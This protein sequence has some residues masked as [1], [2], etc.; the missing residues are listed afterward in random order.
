M[1]TVQVSFL[2][3]SYPLDPHEFI[4]L[5]DRDLEILWSRISRDLEDGFYSFINQQLAVF[6][7]TNQRLTQQTTYH[8]RYGASTLDSS[9]G[10]FYLHFI[11]NDRPFYRLN[12]PFDP[13][14]QGFHDLLHTLQVVLQ[15]EA[16]LVRSPQSSRST[17]PLFTLFPDH[18][19]LIFELL[20]VRGAYDIFKTETLHPSTFEW[21]QLF[22]QHFPA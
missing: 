12:R 9:N 15:I 2:D 13:S 5:S 18:S 19:D 22:S 11:K 4:S 21:M 7:V 20:M 17:S 8:I 16:Y 14:K 3:R 10:A 6:N 1:S